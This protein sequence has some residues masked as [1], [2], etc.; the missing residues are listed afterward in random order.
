MRLINL[1]ELDMNNDNVIVHPATGERLCL[2][3]KSDIVT[4]AAK[5]KMADGR[6][7]LPLN[8][9]SGHYSNSVCDSV[10]QLTRHVGPRRVL[11]LQEGWASGKLLNP[12]V[13]ELKSRSQ[14][15]SKWIKE[16]VGQCIA[17]LLKW[18]S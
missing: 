11:H 7:K 8:Q 2:S 4:F 3:G 10:P 13:Y 9:N 5:G 1:S 15:I 18:P 12:V 14:H 6:G 17:A 16:V